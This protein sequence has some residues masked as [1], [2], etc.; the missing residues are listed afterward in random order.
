MSYELP[1]ST[2]CLNEI[3]YFNREGSEILTGSEY[4]CGRGFMERSSFLNR[5]V[6][7]YISTPSNKRT[8]GDVLKET[9][10]DEATEEITMTGT[11]STS[12]TTTTTTT[13]TKKPL[14]E[15]I[16]P[17]VPP[18]SHILSTTF[19]LQQTSATTTTTT[20]KA[21]LT[22]DKKVSNS[23]AYV[24]ALLSN[25]LDMHDFTMLTQ[26]SDGDVFSYSASEEPTSVL[27]I[28]DRVPA[29]TWR[30]GSIGISKISTKR[31]AKVIVGQDYKTT[32]GPTQATEE[33]VRSGG[34]GGSF[35]CLVEVVK[36]PCECG[37]GSTTKIVG[38][39][40]V[41]GINEFP[42]MAGI[43]S[44]KTQRIF[45]GAAI[46]H[47]RYLLSAGHCYATLD[48]SRA[49]LLQ[50]VVGEHDTSTVYES[51][52][53][54][55]YDISQVIVHEFFRSTSTRVHNDI[56]LL[57]TH[58][59]IE[60]NRSVGPACLPFLPIVTSDGSRKPPISGQR[61]ETAGWGTTSFGGQQSSVLLKTTLD[62]ISREKCQNLIHYLPSGA[63]C[64]YTPGRDTCQYD[65]GGA[66]Y[67]R[68]ERLFAVG[69]V[70]YGFACATDQPSVNTRVASHLKWI[71]SKATDVKFCIK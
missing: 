13:T 46:I 23:F 34:G 42:S 11:S 61:V 36:P 22:E 63:F 45:C 2:E 40:G 71:K 66:M 39:S 20:P 27:G 9:E 33:Y 19:T 53:T 58:H 59:S 8:V 57:K 12:T 16:T 41:A 24:L 70:S 29:S 47:H 60:W 26:S 21:P 51:I 38:A 50:A 28:N 10:T 35:S 17:Q 69:I 25:K 14:K 18:P 15:P 68:G 67:A 44:I 37:W 7:S 64:T 65:S 62:V 3:F 5:A 1:S 30:N 4:F 6:F 52:Y 49:E 54:R 56:A 31:G 43:I 32:I 48:T 55:Y